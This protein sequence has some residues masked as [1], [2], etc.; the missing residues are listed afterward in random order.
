MVNQLLILSLV[1][2]FI[3]LEYVENDG[4]ASLYMYIVSA[5]VT[6]STFWNII[7]GVYYICDEKTNDR[8]AKDSEK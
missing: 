1:P 7:M 4:I 5:I 3:I 6:V 8:Y 2:I